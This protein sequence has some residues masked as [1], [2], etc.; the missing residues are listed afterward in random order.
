MQAQLDRLSGSKEPSPKPQPVAW[1]A[2]AKK[3][4]KTK[5]GWTPERRA[6]AS[7]RMAKQ[8]AAKKAA[9]P[10]PDE[11]ELLRQQMR[12]PTDAPAV[13]P[14]VHQSRGGTVAKSNVDWIKP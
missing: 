9:E 13:L 6:A 4:K 12:P 3:T 7:A 14:K 10:E 8:Q 2:K 11:A 5:G 1:P